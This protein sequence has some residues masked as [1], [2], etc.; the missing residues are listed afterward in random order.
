[1]GSVTNM[2]EAI[3]WLQYTY[4]Y[5]R[6]R[7]NPAL[8]GVDLDEAKSDPTLVRMRLNLIHSAALKLHKSGMIKYDKKAGSLLPTALGKVASH[9]YVRCESMLVYQN[10]LKP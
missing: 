4:L 6:M 2:R 7:R 10:E 9:Y 1:M 3:T 5:V 8:Y